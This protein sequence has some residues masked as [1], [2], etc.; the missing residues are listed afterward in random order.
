MFSLCKLISWR[1]YSFRS[2]LLLPSNVFLLFPLVLLKIKLTVKILNP[3]DRCREVLGQ[4]EAL[5]SEG[6]DQSGGPSITT[7]TALMS[8]EVKLQSNLTEQNPK[9]IKVKTT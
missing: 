3:L 4:K 5:H 7:I 6:K 8:M 2:G 9:F 1:R